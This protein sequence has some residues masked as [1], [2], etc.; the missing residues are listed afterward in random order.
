MK[1]LL[2]ATLFLAVP[3][4]AETV[5]AQASARVHD[6]T[7]V[8][9]KAKSDAKELTVNVTPGN[10][11]SFVDKS[12]RVKSPGGLSW[13]INDGENTES[14]ALF[15]AP[16][17]TDAGGKT[18]ISTFT[19][20]FKGKGGGNPVNWNVKSEI[21]VEKGKIEVVVLGYYG[22]GKMVHTTNTRGNVKQSDGRDV[23]YYVDCHK[24]DYDEIFSVWIK[25]EM[26]GIYAVVKQYISDNAVQNLLENMPAAQFFDSVGGCLSFFNDH[27]A[28]ML[29]VGASLDSTTVRATKVRMHVIIKEENKEDVKKTL[30]LNLSAVGSSQPST[31]VMGGDKELIAQERRVAVDRW[32]KNAEEE[33][34]A[35]NGKIVKDSLGYGDEATVEF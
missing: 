28:V 21:E 5:F 8:K 3:W 20:T 12:G 7:E 13:S 35:D 2:L 27:I 6:S 29:A 24:R 34:R 26:K 18:Y 19:G 33:L 14:R 23:Y 17:P 31:T 15:R 4:C 1:R 10:G 30:T 32:R 16:T 9:A 11:K 22:H 25:E